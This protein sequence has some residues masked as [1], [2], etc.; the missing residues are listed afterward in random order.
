[1]ESK[2]QAFKD[3]IFNLSG[4]HNHEG[5]DGDSKKQKFVCREALKA[6]WEAKPTTLSDFLKDAKL[7]RADAGDILESYLQVWSIVCY[8]AENIYDLRF[9]DLLTSETG[10]I[11]LPL[12]APPS[13][14]P[15]D[16]HSQQ[17]IQNFMEN[18]WMF[19]PLKFGSTMIF[20]RSLAKERILPIEKLD[21]IRKPENYFRYPSTVSKAQFYPCCIT[22]D[23][24]QTVILKSIGPGTTEPAEW[25]NEVDIYTTF[26]YFVDTQDPGPDG[27]ILTKANPFDYITTCFDS[28][29][30]DH[31]E[32]GKTWTITL[33]YAAL[34]NLGQFCEQQASTIHAFK[35]EDKYRFWDRVLRDL[36]QGFVCIHGVDW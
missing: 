4:Q 25:D 21:E 32:A 9:I 13:A 3:Y 34:G 27:F 10:D 6:Y 30:Q 19:A 8:T 26:R 31:G 14:W 12:S 24:P 1:M 36:L 28:W 17:F 11:L 23:R 15:K 20:R 22:G 29:V 2:L 16:R 35:G 33:E 18:Q 7:V 5:T